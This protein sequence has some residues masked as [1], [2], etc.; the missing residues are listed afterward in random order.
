LLIEKE[1][2]DELGLRPG[3][4]KE[5]IT[6]QGIN[7]MA[8]SPGQQLHLGKEVIIEVTGEC[9]PCG[10]MDEIRQGLQAELQGRRG[11][12]GR[13]VVGGAIRC[14]DSVAVG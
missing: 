14:G 10:R 1:T 2:L 12:L 7:L 4:V 6:T 11:M 3:L 13:V 5:N 8:L 9:E